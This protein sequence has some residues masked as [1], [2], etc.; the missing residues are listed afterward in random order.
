[1]AA[2]ADADRVRR[3]AGADPVARTRR[4]DAASVQ[5]PSPCLHRGRPWA[6]PSSSAT[7]CAGLPKP[8]TSLAL[9]SGRM[10]ATRRTGA[11]CAVAAKTT[12]SARTAVTAATTSPCTAARHRR[13]PADMEDAVTLWT[14]GHATRCGGRFPRAADR[15]RYPG[16]GRCTSF[17]GFA[18]PSVVRRPDPGAHPAGGGRGVPVVAAA[19]RAAPCATRLF[20]RPLAQCRLA[21]PCRSPG[22]RRVRRWT[23]AFAGTCRAPPHRADVRRSTVVAPPPPADRGPARRARHRGAADP[24]CR[25]RK[26]HALTATARVVDGRLRHPPAQDD[27]SG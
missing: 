3:R 2:G 23:G 27:L 4:A 5:W 21:G 22:Q 19:G 6:T 7:T 18:A 14:L 16:R 15:L 9:S 17:P 12:G 13:R 25:P 8:A 1:M 20:Q 24:R 11:T 10:P 26:A